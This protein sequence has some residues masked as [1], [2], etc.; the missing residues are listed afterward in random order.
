MRPPTRESTYIDTPYRLVSLAVSTVIALVTVTCAHSPDDGELVGDPV[1]EE[2]RDRIDRQKH[3]VTDALASFIQDTDREVCQSD[4]DRRMAQKV[5]QAMS[6]AYLELTRAVEKSERAA[7]TEDPGTAPSPGVDQGDRQI[8]WISHDETAD[9]SVPQLHWQCLETAEHPEC[10][11]STAN[12]VARLLYRDKI[13]GH[14]LQT[15]QVA[16]VLSVLAED[17]D[18]ALGRAGNNRATDPERLI[19]QGCAGGASPLA[20]H[21]RRNADDPSIAAIRA[22]I[23][24][25][26]SSFCTGLAAT[27]DDVIAT[28]RGQ[29]EQSLISRRCELDD[30]EAL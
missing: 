28:L 24:G 4:Q 9:E 20:D 1:T 12:S 17:I 15:S 19:R 16:D 10:V 25:Q 27:Y 23:A 29:L 3:E 26:Y 21:I 6:E 2:T 18:W 11:E 30:W 5:R 7:R 22:D 8:V 13:G 14:S